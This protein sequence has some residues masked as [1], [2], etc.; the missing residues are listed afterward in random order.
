MVTPMN[1]QPGPQAGLN[2]QIEPADPSTL[3]FDLHNP[4]MA[5]LVFE[6][7]DQ[8]IQHL[9]EQYDV[10]QLVL[11]I[12]TAGWLDY[13]PLIVEDGTQMVIEGNRRLAALH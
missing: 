6:T 10:E 11:S 3:H 7:E 4:R 9:I 5:D 13:E 2:P 12:L 1:G 8:V